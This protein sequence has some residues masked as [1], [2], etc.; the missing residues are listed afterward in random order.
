MKWDRLSALRTP[1]LIVLGALAIA[2]GAFLIYV[3]AG[4]I[5]VG[6][7]LWLIEFLSGDD[8]KGART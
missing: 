3:P 2:G 8:G 7:C 1:F 4:L 6:L 5:A